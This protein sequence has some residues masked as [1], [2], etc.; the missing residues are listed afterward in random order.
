MS[1]EQ[2]PSSGEKGKNKIIRTAAAAAATVAVAAAVTATGATAASASAPAQDGRSTFTV[3]QLDD[4]LASAD[5]EN[6]DN[7]R[8]VKALEIAPGSISAVQYDR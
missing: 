5:L 3:Q 4:M 1:D 7:V 8:V 6:A 2:K